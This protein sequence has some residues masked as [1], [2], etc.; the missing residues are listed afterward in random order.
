MSEKTNSPWDELDIPHGGELSIG[1]VNSVYWG[2]AKSHERGQIWDKEDVQ[3]LLK[4]EAGTDE[5]ILRGPAQIVKGEEL[6][7]GVTIDFGKALDV[8]FDVD[9]VNLHDQT[10]LIDVQKAG[11][12]DS[13]VVTAKLKNIYG[14]RSKTPDHIIIS[15]GL[16]GKLGLDRDGEIKILRASTDAEDL[17]LDTWQ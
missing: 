9:E 3:K 5:L 13:P 14:M 8:L 1:E 2:F 12:N 6:I 11:G 7:V 4:K 16:A 15:K 10:W 17:N